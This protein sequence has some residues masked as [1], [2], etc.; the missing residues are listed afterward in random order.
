MVKRSLESLFKAMYHDRFDY[1]DFLSCAVVDNCELS[2]YRDRE[3]S[4]EVLKPNKKLKVYHK[5]LNLF[6]FE[7]LPI[8]ERVVFSY[9]KGVGPYDAVAPHA[10]SKYFFQTDISAF[11]SSIDRAMVMST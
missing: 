8:N 10:Q 5:F 1:L 7:Q 3:H 9:R 4:R 2:H 6:L 11:F